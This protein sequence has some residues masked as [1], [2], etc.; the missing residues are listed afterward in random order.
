MAAIGFIVFAVA[1]I[2]IGLLADTQRQH[3]GVFSGNLLLGAEVAVLVVI[4]LA[5][6]L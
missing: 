6:S 2:F 3:F 4:G 5:A 1:A